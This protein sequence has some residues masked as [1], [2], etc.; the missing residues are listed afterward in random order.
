M[1]IW[2]TGYSRQDISLLFY[3]LWTETNNSNPYKKYAV[4]RFK[5]HNNRLGCHTR[6]IFRIFILQMYFVDATLKWSIAEFL[7][8]LK[9][10]VIALLVGIGYFLWPLLLTWFNFNP[11]MDK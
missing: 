1:L 11:S 2:F 6:L 8:A 7:F 3:R 5:I 10:I 4:R 9:V